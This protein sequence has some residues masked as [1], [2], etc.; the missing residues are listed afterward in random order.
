MSRWNI[1]KARWG[2]GSGETDDIRMDPVTNILASIRSEHYHMHEGEHYFIKTFVEE[3]GGAGSVT[4]LSFTTPNTAVRIHAKTE[5]SFDVDFTAEI[6]EDATVTG[7]TPVVGLNN[8]RDS[9]NTPAMTALA[10]PT[11]TV[12]GNLIWAARTGGGKNPVG[13]SPGSTY[14]IIAKANSTYTFTLTKNAVQTGIADI[15]FWWY[16]ETPKH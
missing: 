4:I 15:D 13:V 10:G 11:I 12:P 6:H 14:E 8:D 2:S 3:V 1:L 5:L 7:G 16:E 9:I